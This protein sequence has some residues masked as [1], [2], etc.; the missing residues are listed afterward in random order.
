MWFQVI[1][2]LREAYSIHNSALKTWS[3]VVVI[4]KEKPHFKMINFQI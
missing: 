3:Y 1:S 2:N 4:L